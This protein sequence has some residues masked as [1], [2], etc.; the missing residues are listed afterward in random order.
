M[1]ESTNNLTAEFNRKPC[2]TKGLGIFAQLFQLTCFGPSNT[3]FKFSPGFIAG[4][5]PYTC[6]SSNFFLDFRSF[7]GMRMSYLQF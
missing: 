1:Q 5:L 4:F 2:A 7:A 3:V 6:A